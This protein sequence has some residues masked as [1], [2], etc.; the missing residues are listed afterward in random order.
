LSGLPASVPGFGTAV[1]V[2]CVGALLDVPSAGAV[3]GPALTFL[4]FDFVFA[5][6]AC[7]GPR[8]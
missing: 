1:F 3:S 5:I 8:T 2:V 7:S 4:P 6:R